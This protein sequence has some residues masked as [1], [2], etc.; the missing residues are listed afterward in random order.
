MKN[1]SREY[2]A[3]A[4]ATLCFASDLAAQEPAADNGPDLNIVSSR[5]IEMKPNDKRPLS[6]KDEER[7]P[8]AKRAP[9][10]EEV[11]ENSE[12]SQE[13]Q[14][15]TRL[16]EM[17]IGGSSVSSNGI[18]ILV[19][20]ISLEK[21]KTLDQL[22]PD[23]TENLK[24]IDITQNEINFGWLDVETGELTGKTMQIAYDLSPGVRYLLPGQKDSKEPIM[25]YH[26]IEDVRKR[27]AK[28]DQKVNLKN[29]PTAGI[30]ERG[31]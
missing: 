12:D 18:R 8:Y 19:G 29:A 7:N 11:V 14:I 24:V 23:Q 9:E 13:N 20:D 22:I 4:A 30:Y 3:V 31:N 27:K 1:L 5:S 2:I 6:V 16:L 17:P 28:E 26:R 25:G 15:R 10:E 21:G